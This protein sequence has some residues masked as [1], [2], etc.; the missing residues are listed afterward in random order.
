MNSFPYPF[1]K[2]GLKRFALLVLLN[3]TSI[4]PSW[5]QQDV[6]QKR[7]HLQLGEVTISQAL[8]SIEQRTGYTF[9]YS[10]DLIDISRKVTVSFDNATLAD[11]LRKILGNAA[12]GVRV[13]GRQIRI[14]PSQGKGSV[15]GKATTRDGQPASFVNITIAGAPGTRVN[16]YGQFK[17]ANIEAGEHTV[18]ASY[19]GLQS[20]PQTVIVEPGKTTMVN[21]VMNEN[22]ETLQEVVV[23][24]ERN[25]K[26]LTRESDYVSRMPLTNLENPQVYSTINKQ[27]IQDQLVVSMPDAVR[28]AAGAVPVINPSGGF[29]AN[30]RGF[31][32]GANARNGMESTSERSALDLANIDRIEILKGP[33]GTLF[34]AAVSSFGGVVNIVTKKPMDA[35][36]TELTYT[37]GSFGLNRLTA[38]I[39][40]PLNDQKSLLLRVN[41]AIHK[42][43]SFLSYG[44]NNTFLFAP[45]LSYKVNEKLTFSFDGELLNVNNTQPMNFIIQSST[46]TQPKDLLWDYR[47]NLFHNNVD[48]KNYAARIYSSAV[49]KISSSWKSTTLFSYVSENVDHSYQRP[50]IW[51][52][53]STAFRASSV[54]GPVY[55]GYTNIQQNFNG[56]FKTGGIKHKLLLGGNYRQYKGDFLFSEANVIDQIDITKPFQPL[57]KQ[58]IDSAA[59]F[60]PFP[61]PEQRTASV[62]A[63]DAI[64]FTR[65]LSALISL[66]AD[67]F[68]R[69]D[70]PGTTD[71]FKQTSLA[72]KLGL[73]YQILPEKVSLFGNY[74]SSFQNVAPALQP[75]GTRLTLDPIFANQSEGGVKAE[76]L[77]KR[78]SMTASYYYINID[79]ATR[80]NADQFTV[81]DG[82]QVSKGLDIEVI[83]EPV[84]GFNLIAG[85]AYNDNRIKSA[86]DVTVIG[87]KAASSPEQV[88]NLWMSYRF[89]QTLKGFELGFGA[90]YVDKMYR[91]ANNVFFIPSYTLLNAVVSYNTPAWGLQVKSNN[92]A[93]KRYWDMWGNPQAPANFAASLSIKF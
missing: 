40:M 77:N 57:V 78:L 48:V 10:T 22:A 35:K 49:Y 33:S 68:N 63:S 24:G 16:E 83:S 31:G 2:K 59:V 3:L 41:S 7:L 55:N 4:F 53:P 50:V 73:V 32:I 72:P 88:A 13:T 1:L 43:R 26:F 17:L 8:L 44:F 51:R 5:S 84:A 60:A 79:N 14:Q 28:N 46:I 54:Y 37:T 82:R 11:I 71:G 69:K 89:Q 36:K 20:Q 19:I 66:R 38:D 6:L 23:N 25:N 56:E 15:S 61:T 27:L 87:N 47:S 45:S 18:V 86:T 85:Y 42:E 92:L 76:L 81:Q 34:G 52:S 93:D 80:V 74:M 67:H 91:A 30:F 70:N 21:F 75:D 90:N 9:S 64:G 58:S 12:A 65:R 39:N 62:Y 29:S